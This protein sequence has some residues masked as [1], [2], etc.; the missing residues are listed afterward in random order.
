[1]NSVIQIHPLP[2]ACLPEAMRHIGAK[3]DLKK[4]ICNEW[5]Q[6]HSL[7]TTLAKATNRQQN[8]RYARTN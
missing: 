1:M 4:V 5:Q 7:L 6:N 3:A 8:Q 2:L